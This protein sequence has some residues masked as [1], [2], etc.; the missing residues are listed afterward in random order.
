MKVYFNK[1]WENR[2][3]F[4]KFNNCPLWKSTYLKYLDE[5]FESIFIF[6]MTNMK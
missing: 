1:N 2:E 6:S 3:T 5:K 4:T